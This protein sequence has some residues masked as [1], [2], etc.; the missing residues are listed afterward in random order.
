MPHGAMAELH[1]FST[2]IRKFKQEKSYGYVNWLRL[3]WNNV[4]LVDDGACFGLAVGWLAEMIFHRT[5]LF[6]ATTSSDIHK[7][8]RDSVLFGAKNQLLYVKKD[9]LSLF[10]HLGLRPIRN[11]IPRTIKNGDVVNVEDSILSAVDLLEVGVGLLIGVYYLNQ[12]GG[13]TGH[14]VAFFRGPM[15]NLYFFDPSHGV[16]EVLVPDPFIRTWA[17]VHQT[18]FD[19]TLRIEPGEIWSQYLAAG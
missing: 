8:N 11:I 9:D 12:K 16:Y 7:T 3:G 18:S 10:R 19:T 2:K 6:S 1:N 17:S 15:A 14:S 13:V 5:N 4:D